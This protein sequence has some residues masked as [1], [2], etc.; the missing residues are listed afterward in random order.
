MP[1]SWFDLILILFWAG[2]IFN[3]LTKGL[4]RLLGRLVGLI[5]G[6]VMASYFYVPVYQW[7]Q[8]FFSLNE[9]VGKV[10]AFI[11]LFV[12]ITRIVDWLFVWLEKFF[13]VISI[14]PFTKMINRLLG[15][16]LGFLEGA[17]FL[18]LIVYVISRYAWLGGLF[19][20]QLE[21]SLVAPYLLWL[22]QLI[23]PILPEAIKAVQSVMINK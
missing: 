12:V 14:I 22:V 2:F 3:G 23:L 17:L 18:G 10:L 6:A 1:I 19:G 13:K 21:T 4:I 16:A 7:S 15:G 8:N 9:G 5:V 11:V 20:N